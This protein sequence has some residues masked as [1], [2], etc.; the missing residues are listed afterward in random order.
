MVFFSLFLCYFAYCMKKYRIEIT[1]TLSRTVDVEAENEEVALEK[2]RQM[3]RN[4][5]IILDAS[6]YLE[7]EISVKR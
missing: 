6:D 2:V 3:Y 1:E 7:T 5:A 4:S